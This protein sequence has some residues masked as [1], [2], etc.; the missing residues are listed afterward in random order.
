MERGQRIG[1]LVA[2]VVVA[3]AAFIVIGGGGDDDETPSRT[4]TQTEQTRPGEPMASVPAPKPR[5]QAE[6]IVIANGEIRGGEKRVEVDKGDTIRI[7]VR[8]D[9]AD[10]L[11]LHGYDL[12]TALPAGTPAELSFQATV[13]GVFEVELHDAGTVLLTLQVS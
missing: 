3:V 5:P 6:R 13:P 4:E 12:R 2:A 9:V 7:D 10:E 8:A 1:L 11:H